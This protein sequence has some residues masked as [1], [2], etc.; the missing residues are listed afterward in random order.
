MYDFTILAKAGITPGIAAKLVGVSRVTASQWVNG[1]AS[2]HRLLGNKVHE[3][4]RLVKL[5]LEQKLLPLASYPGRHNVMTEISKALVKAA[6]DQ[7]GE[8]T[9]TTPA[10]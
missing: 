1:H 6:K 10:S 7:A 5:A 4:L 3:F 8:Q 9:A 2:P